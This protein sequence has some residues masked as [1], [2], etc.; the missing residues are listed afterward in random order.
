MVAIDVIGLLPETANG[1]RS[2]IAFT[3]CFTKWPEAFPIKN[4]KANTVAK[5][6]VQEVF[7]C[8][9]VPMVL[10]SNRG[11]NF[12]SSLIKEICLLLHI[13]KLRTTPYHPE[14]DGLVK[15][16]NQTLIRVLKSY[17][18][19]NQQQ[20]DDWIPLALLSYRTSR[21]SS[22]QRLHSS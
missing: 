15:R 21:Q 18:S 13:C 16:L 20:W 11:R 5:V 19:E 12:E 2:I 14:G 4:Q 6:L 3:D 1:N 9:G 17:V 22:T 7:S 8:Y 10:H